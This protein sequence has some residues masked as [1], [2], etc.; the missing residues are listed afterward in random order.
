MANIIFYSITFLLIK[1]NELLFLRHL[2]T[3]II[4]SKANIFFFQNPIRT[5]FIVLLTTHFNII[6]VLVQIHTLIVATLAIYEDYIRF[7]LLLKYC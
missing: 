5:H 6:I 7:Y 3:K 4:F 2:F 1:Y